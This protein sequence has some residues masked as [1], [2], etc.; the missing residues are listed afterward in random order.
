MLAIIGG[1]GLYA[2]EGATVGDTITNETPFGSPSAPL[3]SMRY[4]DRRFVFLPRHG[5]QHQLLPHEINYAANIFALK[6]LGVTQILSVSAVGSLRQQIAPGEFVI[7]SQYFDHVKGNRRRSFFGDGLVA[8]I[9]S[10]EPS[11]RSLTD[12]VVTQA[13][14]MKIA[15]HTDATYGCVDGP[16]L[17]TKAESHFLRT[18][19]CDL[20]GMTNVPEVF[21]AREA[22]ICY[23]TLGIVTDYDCWMDDT[24][25]RVTVATVIARYSERIALVKALLRALLAQP[26]PKEDSCRTALEDAILTSNVQLSEMHKH[27]LAVLR[28]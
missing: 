19:G 22:Q 28:I 15:L 10:A 11:C 6:Q 16:R 9:S 25:Q 13:K 8:H 20:V 4:Q 18:I 14:Q 1:T 2:L 27:Y 23:T 5:T 3:F 21:L 7:P 17:G 24:K 26:L 12:W